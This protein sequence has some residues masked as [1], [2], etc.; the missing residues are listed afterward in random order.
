[1]RL[2]KFGFVGICTSASTVSRSS[3]VSPLLSGPNNSPTLG[4]KTNDSALSKLSFVGELEA[5]TAALMLAIRRAISGGV[6][7]TW[8]VSRNRAVVAKVAVKS[9]VASAIVEKTRVRSST[10]TD[11]RMPVRVRHQ[12]KSR[13]EGPQ[14]VAPPFQSSAWLEPQH[15]HSDRE[16]V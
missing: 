13:I 8:V 2:A 9:E 16:K 5:A 3:F 4:L 7:T 6:T 10:G 14:D 12:I 15:R 11:A 1:M